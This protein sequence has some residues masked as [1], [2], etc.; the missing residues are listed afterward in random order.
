MS[1]FR[2]TSALVLIGA[3]CLLSAA[4]NSD[5][6]S[7]PA[8]SGTANLK[9][10]GDPVEM[11]IAAV[12]I[13]FRGCEKA[14]GVERSRQEALAIATEVARE[15]RGGADFKQLAMDKS[16]GPRAAAGGMF[17]NF[18]SRNMI[19]QVV[20]ATSELEVGEISEPVET[21]FGYYVILRREVETVYNASH[22][23]I[24]HKD[25]IPNP[26]NITRT[27]EEALALA[28]EI[29]EKV[30]AGENFN[31]LALMHSNGPGR[32][33]GGQLGNFTI[34]Q[35]PAYFEQVGDK[36]SEIDV[37]TLSEPFE[38]EV[39]VHIVKRQALPKPAIWLAAKHVLV[40]YK[41]AERA[42]HITRSKEE[43]RERI[44]TVQAKLQAGEK[45][46]DLAREYS[47]CPSN[48]DGGDLGNFQEH[49]M[50]RAFS[51]ATLECVVGGY[52]DIVETPFG[53]HL[54]H[55]YELKL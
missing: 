53:F 55:R 51:D 44:E 11:N 37:D 38:T 32:K 22:I 34:G 33:V 54:I 2:T 23:L 25:S 6:G 17:G 15:A 48:K 42:G 16:D 26:G 49:K 8:A 4:C 13:Q 29:I 46:E 41:G 9:E 14:D 10:I 1:L 12:L 20:E 21:Q 30:D 7:Q 24:L 39:G 31:Q 35:L 36:V 28:Q 47:D 40:M 5:S 3:V 45:F 19:N 43:A 50:A 27:K 18:D 52:T